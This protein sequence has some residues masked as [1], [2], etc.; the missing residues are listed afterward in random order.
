MSFDCTIKSIINHEAIPGAQI[1]RGHLSPPMLSIFSE[2]Q[3]EV[4]SGCPQAAPITRQY[5]CSLLHILP[6]AVLPDEELAYLSE[7]LQGECLSRN[8]IGVVL[9]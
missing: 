1:P 5:V 9:E 3:M 6:D 7:E 8:V 4:R 2:P